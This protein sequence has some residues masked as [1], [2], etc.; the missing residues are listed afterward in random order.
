MLNS[1]HLHLYIVANDI[2]SASTVEDATASFVNLL[3]ETFA[4]DSYTTGVLS[5]D[6]EGSQVFEGN[7]FY[8]L[9]FF[10]EYTASLLTCLFHSLP[11]PLSC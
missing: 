7:I 10:C 6:G 2:L 1:L 3:D 9:V 8:A 5:G 11:L 4:N